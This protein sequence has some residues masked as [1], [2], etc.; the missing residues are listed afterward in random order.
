M[1]LSLRK[2]N[3]LTDAEVA[4]KLKL[5]RWPSTNGEPVCPDCACDAVYVIATRSQYRCKRCGH[6]FS[7]ISG[8]VFHSS[9]LS[10]RS[11]LQLGLLWANAA[12]GKSALELRRDIGL[13]HK[14]SFVLLHKLREALLTTA[15]DTPM[16][17]DVEIDGMH[18]GG[19]IR[20]ANR[21]ED[22]P[23]Q[24]E[25]PTPVRCVLALCQRNPEHLGGSMRTRVQVVETET[26][27][28]A[29]DFITR[30]VVQGTT[31][32]S[33]G[34]AG[35]DRIGMWYDLRRVNH[36]RAY[37]G[38][39][40]EN[41]NLCENYFS[42]FRRLQFGQVHKITPKYLAEYANEI[43]YRADT[44]RW[45][46]EHITHDILARALQ[47]KRT[48]TFRRYWHSGVVPETVQEDIPDDVQLGNV[49]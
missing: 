5:L 49:G 18:V 24:N 3:K 26:A 4:D 45:T 32:Y 48:E 37:H 36:R 1:K 16:D 17:G 23:E 40:G 8:T 7:I 38:D 33:D 42:R 34:H 25:A 39:N 2:I 11:I 9:K 13:N 30:N 47:T 20:H 21:A 28:T 6:T 15:D 29:F 46:N 19:H 41:I 14:S 10:L 43:A 31:I 12:K 44:R 27:E 22:R 35:Y